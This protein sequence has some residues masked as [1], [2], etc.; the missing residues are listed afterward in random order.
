MAKTNI[1]YFFVYIITFPHQNMAWDRKGNNVTPTESNIGNTAGNI[2]YC[3]S[4]LWVM[5]IMGLYHGS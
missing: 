5:V 4:L 2:H 3:L 1:L